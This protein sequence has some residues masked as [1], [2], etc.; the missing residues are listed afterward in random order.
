MYCI[1]DNYRYMYTD[2]RILY[3]P[4]HCRYYMDTRHCYFMSLYDHYTD[5]VVPWTWY[6]MLHWPL[7][8]HV[9]VIHIYVIWIIATRICYT[10]TIHGYTDIH[11]YTCID[12]LYIFLL[13][14]FPSCYPVTWLFPVTSI[15]ILFTR[16]ECCWYAMCGTKC[17]VDLSHGGHL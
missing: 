9:L 13:H 16:Y 5:T 6:Y 10:D 17:H 8:L 3:Y 2:S 4:R 7:L 15:D 11:R 12:Y 1:K 14:V